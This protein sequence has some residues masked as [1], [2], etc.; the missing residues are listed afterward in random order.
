MNGPR[1]HLSD[2][3]KAL[4]AGQY[5]IEREKEARE[6][7]GGAGRFGGTVSMDT[8]PGRLRPL[9]QKAAESFGVSER[10]VARAVKVL[11]DSV[12]ELAD[13]VARGAW[14]RC[15]S[16]A[17]GRPSIASRAAQSLVEYQPTCL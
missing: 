2:N 17:R 3:E 11:K 14:R 13:A 15:A 7:Q 1:R 5:A 16:P 9:R 8:E 4:A 12:P 10:T 6:R